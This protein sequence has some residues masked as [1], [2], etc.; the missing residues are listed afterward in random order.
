MSGEAAKSEAEKGSG[1]GEA[2]PS[3]VEATDASWPRLDLRM[4]LSGLRFRT[5]C[6]LFSEGL[7]LE[8]RPKAVGLCAVTHGEN[9][10]FLTDLVVLF[11]SEAD[12]KGEEGC[13]GLDVAKIVWSRSCSFSQPSMS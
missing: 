10:T 7:C 2:V 5:E 13:A 4:D 12:D 1:I 11:L 6:R 8:A 3:G 9:S